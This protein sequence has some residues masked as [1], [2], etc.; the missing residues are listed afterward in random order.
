MVSEKL[1]SK[2][3]TTL[4]RMKDGSNDSLL[5]S[6]KSEAKKIFE[7]F[8][9][10]HG[11]PTSSERYHATPDDLT[12]LA[13]T[14]MHIDDPNAEPSEEVII[15]PK[16]DNKEYGDDVDTFDIFADNNDVSHAYD[17]LDYAA[18]AESVDYKEALRKM[19]NG[20][21]DALIEALIDGADAI[22]KGA[23]GD[24]QIAEQQTNEEPAPAGQQKRW[25]LNRGKRLFCDKLMKQ[26][27]PLV[28][29]L[30]LNLE[31]FTKFMGGKQV[32]GF[33][34]TNQDED[35][36]MVVIVYDNDIEGG[37][38]VRYAPDMDYIYT[39]LD[40][41]FSIDLFDDEVEGQSIGKRLFL[42]TK[43]LLNKSLP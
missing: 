5:E 11:Y 16:N 36:V 43:V 34:V 4:D 2:F 33:Y 24:R 9:P 17:D 8:D 6:I 31:G 18:V 38:D 10:N 32:Y 15:D 12:E 14:S 19:K 13:G 30:G 25:E 28:A 1:Q 26:F 7:G 3:Y 23:E 22:S 29:P 41:W 42:K 27:E 37:Y 20:R 21:N 39:D 40:Q 35:T